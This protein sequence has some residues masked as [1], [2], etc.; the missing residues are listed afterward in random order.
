MD[1]S[2]WS[3]D[4][5]K[6]SKP[7]DVWENPEHGFEGPDPCYGRSDPCHGEVKDSWG[8]RFQFESSHHSGS[9]VLEKPTTPAE[10]AKEGGFDGICHDN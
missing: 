6:G 5:T 7:G 2:G 10:R 1:A 4:A 9:L 3:F 8:G